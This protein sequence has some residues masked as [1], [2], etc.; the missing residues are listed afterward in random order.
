[1]SVDVEHP[2]GY[3]KEM[4]AKCIT[5]QTDCITSTNHLIIGDSSMERRHHPIDCPLPGD[6]WLTQGYCA[7]LFP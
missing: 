1:V 3:T 5:V 7:F 2:V 6:V 4:I